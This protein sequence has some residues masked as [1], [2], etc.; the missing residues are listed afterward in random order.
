MSRNF[1]VQFIIFFSEA[2]KLTALKK[3]KIRHIRNQEFTLLRLTRRNPF[4]M[5]LKKW[6]RNGD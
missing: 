2:V 4:S 3:S 1:K 5:R 6:M